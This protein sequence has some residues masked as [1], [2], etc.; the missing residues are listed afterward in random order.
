[1]KLQSRKN[2]VVV[3]MD[4]ERFERLA[5]DFGLFSR[6]FLASLARAERDIKAERLT[7]IKSLKD[8]R[9]LARR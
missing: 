1:M 7:K 5:A 8:V 6:D 2:H 9:D 3:E 4:A